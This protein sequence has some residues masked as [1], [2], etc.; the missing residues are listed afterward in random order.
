MTESDLSKKFWL[1]G[2]QIII[3]V[4]NH[5]FIKAVGGTTLLEAFNSDISD[6]SCLWIFECTVYVHISK[7][8]WL[9]SDKFTFRTKK[10]AFIKY[11]ASC[12]QLWD[13]NKVIRFKNVIFNESQF[14]TKWAHEVL[15]NSLLDKRDEWIM[16]IFDDVT[17]IGRVVKQSHLSSSPTSSLIYTDLSENNDSSSE[18]LKIDI[19]SLITPTN[20][21]S[22]QVTDN[23]TLRD[24]KNTIVTVLINSES[25]DDT[26]SLPS[27]ED[28]SENKEVHSKQ[29]HKA[30]VHF[31]NS[32]DSSTKEPL[33]KVDKKSNLIINSSKRN[34]SVKYAEFNML[35]YAFHMRAD[36]DDTH[37]ES[38]FTPNTFKKAV[39]CLESEFWKQSMQSKL[40]SHVNN[41]TY[42]LVSHSSVSS[43][44]DVISSHW[45]YKKKKDLQDNTVKYKTY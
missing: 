43:D 19:L 4:K 34:I 22:H 45:V 30:S 1:L 41:S 8:D 27:D 5:S 13:D 36:D 25:D 6:L 7:E 10:C 3:H 44:V 29:N 15:D 16:L 32:V 14:Y 18:L 39:S 24:N 37:S 2:L 31:D 42:S 17:D 38:D 20:P 26:L 9:K 12:W 40:Q 11:E 33:S 35:S 28:I 23:V 21:Q